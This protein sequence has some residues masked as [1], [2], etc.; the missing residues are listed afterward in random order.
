MDLH[1]SIKTDI[2][3]FIEISELKTHLRGEQ[4]AAISRDDDTVI[5]SAIDG[6]IAEAKGYLAAYD[7]NLI[8]ATSGQDRNQ[9]LLIFIKDIAVYH[10][11][12]LSNVATGYEIRQRRYDRAIEWL[13]SVQKGDVVPDLPVKTDVDGNRVI[14]PV[15][16]GSNTKRDNH[17]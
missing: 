6:A 2:N 10:F 4:L 1:E 3:M 13:K 9:L 5:T 8:F 17:F 15:K 12:N 7:T 16:F 11:V 14:N